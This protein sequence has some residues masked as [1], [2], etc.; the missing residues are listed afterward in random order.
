[1]AVAQN[2]LHNPYQGLPNGKIG[3]AFII[4]NVVGGVFDGFE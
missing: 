4:D 3:S 2:R 1:M